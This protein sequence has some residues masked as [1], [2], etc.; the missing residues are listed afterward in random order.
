MNQNL[1]K[2]KISSLKGYAYIDHANITIAWNIARGSFCTIDKIPDYHP[3]MISTF[4]AGRLSNES[5]NAYFSERAIE[6]IRAELFPHCISRFL[7]FFMFSDH[8]ISSLEAFKQ[9]S[10]FGKNHFSEEYF[11]E[12]QVQIADDQKSRHDFNWIE[13]IIN[14][15]GSL[16]N[17]WEKYSQQYWSGQPAPNKPPIWETIIN[18]HIKILNKKIIQEAI[19][20]ISSVWPN[21]FF[22]FQ[23][24]LL[25]STHNE[26][27]SE[28]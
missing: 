9:S 22:I 23:Y 12:I 26:P 2:T 16:S 10:F 18:G 13:L 8:D 20:N 17:N 11:S 24:G 1:K 5:M 19:S 25:T 7:G 3:S 21:S 4:F 27:N 15:D 28:G 14:K 6:R